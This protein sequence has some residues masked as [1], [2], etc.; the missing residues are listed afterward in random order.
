MA[1]VESAFCIP[2]DQITNDFLEYNPFISWR[3][4]YILR[5]VPLNNWELQNC[6]TVSSNYTNAL[7]RRHCR[8]KL[9]KLMEGKFIKISK[10][11]MSYLGL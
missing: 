2:N 9:D 3:L 1:F 11:K 5:D 8:Q 10:R 6:D 7:L 4:A